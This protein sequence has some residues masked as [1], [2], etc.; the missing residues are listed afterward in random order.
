VLPASN[1]NKGE[2]VVESSRSSR[3]VP[4]SKKAEKLKAV[5]NGNKA[6][7]VAV[8]MA[9]STSTTSSGGGGGNNPSQQA[10]KQK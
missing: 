5:N 10:V 7:A 2:T 9:T 6:V 1:G 3:N 8:A 4:A